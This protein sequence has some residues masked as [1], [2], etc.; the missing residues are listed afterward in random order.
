MPSSASPAPLIA[1]SVRL[2]DPWGEIEYAVRLDS[3]NAECLRAPRAWRIVVA[4]EQTAGRGRLDR[5]WSTTAY[6]SLAVSAVVPHGT[7]LPVTWLP[8]AAGVA[9]ER[10]V[11]AVTGL[12]AG[13]KWPNDVLLGAPPGKVAGILC[14]WHPAG[15]VVGVGINV[16]TERA[17]LPT[18]QATSLRV[19]GAPGTSREELLGAYLASL[20][21]VVRTSP[22]EVATAYRS[23]CRTLGQEVDVHEPGG[24]V[25]RGVAHDIDDEGRL[26]LRSGTEVV[27]VSVGDVVH[28]REVR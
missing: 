28:V 23:V 14:Q 21:T 15:V 8:L 20:A 2:T 1:G 10:A 22:A 3:T 12:R 13:L 9:V 4:E 27:T 26:V 16:D 5:T 11:R 7:S 17:D 6:T 19:A 18:P 25:R 24:R